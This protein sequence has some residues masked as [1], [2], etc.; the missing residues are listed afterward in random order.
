MPDDDRYLFLQAVNAA[1]ESL[2]LSYLGRDVRDNS[3]F[4]QV[5]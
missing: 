1:K 3:R 4:P 5:S 2:Y